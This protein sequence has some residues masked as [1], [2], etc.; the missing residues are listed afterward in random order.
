MGQ[1]AMPQQPAQ[2][3]LPIRQMNIQSVVPRDTS[4]KIPLR[5]LTRK[6]VGY[7]KVKRQNRK[8]R[9]AKSDAQEDDDIRAMRESMAEFGVSD[10]IEDVDLE[11]NKREN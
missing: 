2:Q 9:K 1:Q 8:D 6:E 11:S 7:N 10:F 3:G 4:I 5:M